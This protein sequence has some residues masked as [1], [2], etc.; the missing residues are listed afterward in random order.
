MFELTT[1]TWP[2][3][4]VVKL[5]RV[6][7]DAQYKDVVEFE[8]IKAREDYFSSLASSSI[9]LDKMSYCKFG[10]PIKVNIPFHT[11]YTYNYLTVTNKTKDGKERT[12][13]YFITD[14]SFSAPETSVLAVQ[15]DV[16]QSYLFNFRIGQMFVER[17]HK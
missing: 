17:S 16:F 13:Y 11:A 15:L 7:W 14:V 8:S 6:S 9:V 10:Q 5:F 12:F 4:S 1:K 2:A 3:G